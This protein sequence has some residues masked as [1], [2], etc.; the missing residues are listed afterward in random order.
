MKTRLVGSANQEVFNEF[1]SDCNE[2][3]ENCKSV[4]IKVICPLFTDTRRIGKLKGHLGEVFCCTTKK[5]LLISTKAF[6][7][8]QK[9]RLTSLSEVEKF[10]E[11]INLDAKKLIHNLTKTNGHN[12]QE[13]YALVP[14]EIIT[15]SIHQQLTTI[16]DTIVSDPM[17]AAKTFLRIAKNNAAMK[18]EFSVFN[19]LLSGSPTLHRKSHPIRKVTL[20]I[21]HGFS[22][23]FAEKNIQVKFDPCEDYLYFDYEMVHVA[24]YHLFDNASKYCLPNTKIIVR[25]DDSGSTFDVVLSMI[26]L[27]VEEEDKVRL[28][29]KYSGRIAKKLGIAGDGIGLGRVAKI[30]SLD[31]AKLFLDYQ[32]EKHL[33][34][35]I[36]GIWY[37]NNHF[38]ITFKNHRKSP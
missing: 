29:E 27:R 8:E 22:Q 3:I 25:F 7:K 31:N 13:L 10:K 35:K 18:T 24:L 14:Q 32:V 12:I 33:S 17:E 20:N 6:K 38:G 11:Q 23:K 34:T 9:L 1:T 4:S 19:K 36:K 5:G 15:Q 2:C 30:L 16:R 37:D 26:S 21:Y 28:L